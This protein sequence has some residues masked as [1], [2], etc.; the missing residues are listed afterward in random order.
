MSID[1]LK[2]PFE[3]SA[4]GLPDE[5][6]AILREAWA[7]LEA[8]G[9]PCSLVSSRALLE[10]PVSMQLLVSPTWRSL[11]TFMDARV[12]A[13]EYLESDIG[14]T[15]LARHQARE[16]SYLSL[17]AQQGLLDDMDGDKA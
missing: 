15:V 2:Q 5:A 1:P 14:R 7:K 4:L 12:I 6:V 11:H 17:A 9:V 10:Q 8:I 13:G 3:R 16:D